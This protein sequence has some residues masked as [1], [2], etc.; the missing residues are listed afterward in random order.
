V[1]D[2]EGNSRRGVLATAPE[3]LPGSE[4]AAC[5]ERMSGGTREAHGCL[6]EVS[7]GSKGSQSERDASMGGGSL[8]ST[9][10][11][12]QRPWREGGEQGKLFGEG[13]TAAPEAEVPVSSKLAELAA[14][15]KKEERLTN[16]VQFVDEGL[17]RL[18]FR[19]LRKQAAPGVDGRSY[20]DY[21]ENLDQNLKDLHRR[22]TTGLYQAPVVRR[23]YIPKANGGRRPLGITTVEDRIVQKAVAWVLSAVYEQDFLE[24][25]HG[26]RPKRSAHTA[27]H[28]LREGMMQHWVK[29]VVEVDVV[30]YFD[31]VGHEWLRKFL[32]H[33]VNDGG[34]LRLIG[35][36]L[37]AGVMENGVVTRTEDGT[38]QGGPV[39]PVIANVY[40]H[41]VL[42][43]WFERRFKK[44]CRRWA[45]L[46]R[47]CDDFVVA[48][49][50]QGDAERFRREVEE[51]LAVFGLQVAPEKTA[52]LCFDGNLLKGR[53]WPSTKPAS[54][55][56]LGF[57]HHLMKTS[58]GKVNIARRPS[59]KGR[60][61][62]LSA[63]T[64]W[65]KANKHRRV[66]EQQAYLT[67]ALNGY[68]QYFGLR[69]CGP[70]L[71]TV[72]WRVY[73]LWRGTLQRR[74]QKARRTCDW[75]TLNKKPWFQLPPP[76]LAQAWV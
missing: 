2:R 49:Q 23:V 40:L 24:C 47:Y 25:S 28:R 44:S 45:E 1:L 6:T 14:R 21:A 74:S 48:F 54:F 3:T 57:V 52:V 61:R 42:D 72:R 69:L 15:A 26:F 27:L 22:L 38:P 34:L 56:F 68:Y 73:R 64:A 8:R 5:L 62:F 31:H 63:V 29:Y 58:A 12:G 18:A 46:T 37:K 4:S 33:R 35:K 7:S 32:R 17:L 55:T 16:V 70:A 66:W 60:E 13:S 51:R 67:R 10:E 75:G 53:G 76:R 39:S 50:D 20:A 59:P 9:E 41:Y 36:W 19:S 43:L 30:G 65:L 71:T 11:A